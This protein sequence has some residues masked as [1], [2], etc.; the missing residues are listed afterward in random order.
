[1]LLVAEVPLKISALA[2]VPCP[3]KLSQIS[4]AAEVS[5]AVC[6]DDPPSPASVR[7]PKESELTVASDCQT[8]SLLD[9]LYL[10]HLGLRQR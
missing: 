8:V 10:H 7:D 3:S 4:P 5:R 6:A 9:Q 2:P 1:M